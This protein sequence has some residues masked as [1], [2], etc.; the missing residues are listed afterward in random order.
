MI[1]TAVFL[2]TPVRTVAKAVAAES[3]D[4]AVKA[5]STGKERGSTL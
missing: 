1:L 4:D 2:V 3:S 5:I